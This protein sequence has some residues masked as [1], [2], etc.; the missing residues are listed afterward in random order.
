MN[1]KNFFEEKTRV[2]RKK[3]LCAIG[4]VIVAL[5]IFQAGI[6]VGYHKAA[7]SYGWGERY[8]KTFGERGERGMRGG[9]EHSFGIM[10]AGRMG[11]SLSNSHGTIGKIISVA[12]P[13]IIIEDQD[14]I[15]K[16]VV[17]TNDTLLR[18]FRDEIRATDLKVGDSV[19][20]IGA[21]NEQAQIEARLI[22]IMPSIPVGLIGTTTAQ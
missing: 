12:L 8:Y 22:R 11:M 10:D 4:T 13:T 3:I 17:L 19:V 21:P 1:I 20:I 18:S 14:R 5:V 7:Y 9:R 16:T 15:E 6:F 2:S